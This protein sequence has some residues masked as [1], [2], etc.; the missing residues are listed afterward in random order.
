LILAILAYN[1]FS[2]IAAHMA[3]DVKVNENKSAS[4]SALTLDRAL[5]PIEIKKNFYSVSTFSVTQN[6]RRAHTKK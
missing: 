3:R 2:E 5:Q 4:S 6:S 1:R